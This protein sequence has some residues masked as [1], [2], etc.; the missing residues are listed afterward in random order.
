MI[1]QLAA[2][3][4]PIDLFELIKRQV[5]PNLQP[6]KQLFTQFWKKISIHANHQQRCENYVQLTGL[7]SM[8]GVG[9]ERRT[10]RA[11]TVA[12][13]IRKFNLWAIG[14]YNEKLVKE[15][16]K[17]AVQ[18]LQGS[19]KV[20]LYLDYLDKYFKRVDKGRKKLGKANLQNIRTRLS[21]SKA[22]KKERDKALKKYAKVLEKQNKLVKAE[23]AAGVDIQARVD[24][25]I[26]LRIMTKKNNFEDLVDVEILA[27]EITMNKKKVTK[28]K[29]ADL[30][31]AEKRKLLRQD[32]MAK[33]L[34]NAGI[35][36]RGMKEAD[37]KHIIP[38]SDEMKQNAF[39]KQQTILDEED[40]ID[41][42]VAD[43]AA[44]VNEEQTT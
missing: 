11:I 1:E 33:L 42:Y 18:K 8:T 30:T 40:K 13:I 14:H 17:P 20:G 16:N 28:K 43:V 7:I 21:N 25:G 3:P 10:N 12:S 27:R 4:E 34:T 6:Y 32:E 5:P 44:M 15:G 37:V 23:E 19:P 22:S 2:E 41:R 29:L 31:I 38:V 24:G 26:L 36:Q 35:A 39:D 9:E